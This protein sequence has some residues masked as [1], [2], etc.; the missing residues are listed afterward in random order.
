MSSFTGEIVLKKM[1]GRIW[2]VHTSFEYHVG[3]KES[4]D[5]II[6]PKGLSTDFASIPQI[7]WSIAPPDGKYTAAAIKKRM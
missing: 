4:N 2:E 6:V 1:G 3:S 7:F 5:I